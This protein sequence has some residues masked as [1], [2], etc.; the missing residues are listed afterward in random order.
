MFVSRVAEGGPAQKAGLPPGSLVLGLE[1]KPVESLEDFYRQLWALGPPGG[2]I[3][4]TIID[5]T[6][7]A[8]EV[9][10]VSADRYDWLELGPGN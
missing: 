10:I 4:L 5:P 3:H 7:E 2:A 9:E 8:R 1:G 6:G